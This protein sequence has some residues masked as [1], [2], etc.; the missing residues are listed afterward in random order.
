MQMCVYVGVYEG[1]WG[2]RRVGMDNTFKKIQQYFYES[3]TS[4]YCGN[5]L[6]SQF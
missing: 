2:E 3:L 5:I 1:A 4:Q 6:V